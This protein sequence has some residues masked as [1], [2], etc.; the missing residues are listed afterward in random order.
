MVIDSVDLLS[1]QI[2]D[3]GLAQLFASTQQEAVK[4]QLQDEMSVRRL[5]SARHQEALNTQEAALKADEARR[6]SATGI[7]E[8][9]S[10][11]QVELRAIQLQAEREALSLDRRQQNDRKVLDFE[12]T[13]EKLVSESSAQKRLREAEAEAS[14]RDHLNGSDQ[15][16]GTAM[17][18]VQRELARALAEADAVRLGAIQS[19]LVGA[20][21]AASDSEVMK[22]AASNMNL[23]SLLGGRSPAEILG[24]IVRGTPLERSHESMRSRSRSGRAADAAPADEEPQDE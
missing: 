10:L 24:Q 18:L 11:H 7:L 9:E 19:E 4:L 21:H 16:H 13:S 23:V 20:L 8:A 6:K 5:S 1:V 22:A 3:S 15:K 14:A 2:M 12:V 17:A